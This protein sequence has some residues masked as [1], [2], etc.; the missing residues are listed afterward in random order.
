[1]SRFSKFVRKNS[2]LLCIIDIFE[3][4]ILFCQINLRY[5]I[6]NI[7]EMRFLS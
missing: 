3:K 7:P 2:I 5:F 4:I 6:C 1:M